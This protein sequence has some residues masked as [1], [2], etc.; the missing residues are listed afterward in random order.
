LGKSDKKIQNLARRTVGNNFNQRF[1]GKRRQSLDGKSVGV[2]DRN[3]NRTNVKKLNNWNN[4]MKGIVG[5]D[6]ANVPPCEV[7][8]LNDVGLFGRSKK[9]SGSGMQTPN[10]GTVVMDSKDSLGNSNFFQSSK[11][12]RRDMPKC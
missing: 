11:K 7:V 4:F 12:S 1:D 3:L 10:V 5:S 6:N 8:A 2:G 9:G